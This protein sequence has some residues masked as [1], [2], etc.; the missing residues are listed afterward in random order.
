[1]ALIALEIPAYY[2]HKKDPQAL[3]I[4]NRVL[5]RSSDRWSAGKRSNKKREIVIFKRR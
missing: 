3:Y 4:F 5:W 2:T 1:M